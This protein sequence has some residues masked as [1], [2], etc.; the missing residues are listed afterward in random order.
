MD[1]MDKQNFKLIQLKLEPNTTEP[2]SLLV[3]VINP[4]P[5]PIRLHYNI[6]GP[7]IHHDCNPGQTPLIIQSSVFRVTTVSQSYVFQ[8]EGIYSLDTVE[9]NNV[10]WFYFRDYV[11]PA[12][13]DPYYVRLLNLKGCDINDPNYLE[14]YILKKLFEAEEKYGKKAPKRENLKHIGIKPIDKIIKPIQGVI[15]P[16]P[17]A[18][19]P[20][21]IRLKAEDS[22][23]NLNELYIKLIDLEASFKKMNYSLNF[24]IVRHD[25]VVVRSNCLNLI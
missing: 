22:A 16:L 14:Y 1:S 21:Q 19:H 18:A 23:A 8:G 11:E 12:I 4:F 24:T 15:Q 2:A 10:Y 20:D 6:D 25:K 5:I 9:L 7:S 13:L 17:I 3:K